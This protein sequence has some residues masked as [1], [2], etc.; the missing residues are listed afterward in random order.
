M[1]YNQEQLIISCGGVIMEI[2]YLGHACFKLTKNNF[3][4]ITDPY[5]AGSVPGL[6]PLKETANLAIAS[7][8]HGD[9]SGVDE[10][11]ISFARCDTPF[12]MDFI[13]TYHDDKEGTL[14]GPNRISILTADD[15]KI[16]HMG[17]IGCMITEEELEKISGCDVLMIPVGGFFTVDGDQAY[18]Y[19]KLINP[20]MVIPMHYR[21]EGFGYDQ[22]GTVDAFLKHFDKDKIIESDSCIK[23]DSKPEGG[24]VMLMKPFNAR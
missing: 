11:K 5:K 12:G 8:Q 18:E 19:Y 23:I 13:D 16:V 14:R 20:G 24:K 21:G 3:S 6:A 7:H 2:T 10:V 15:L 22:I 1:G 4:V 17:D 9:H